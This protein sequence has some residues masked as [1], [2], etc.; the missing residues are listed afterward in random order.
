[1]CTA[2][3]NKQMYSGI[4]MFW[5]MYMRYAHVNSNN[6]VNVQYSTM[7]MYMKCLIMCLSLQEIDKFYVIVPT[8]ELVTVHVVSCLIF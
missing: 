4:H 7:Y 6:H 5:Y 1:M 3:V 2:C 8:E